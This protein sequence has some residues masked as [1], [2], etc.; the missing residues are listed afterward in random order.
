MINTTSTKKDRLTRSR[1]AGCL[2]LVLA[3]IVIFVGIQ[4]AWD[5][6]DK[7]VRIDDIA[8]VYYDSF[9]NYRYLVRQHDGSMKMESRSYMRADVRIYDDTPSED[10][11]YALEYHNATW[12]H[13]YSVDRVEIHIHKTSSLKAGEIRNSH[14][15][16]PKEIKR[17]IHEPGNNYSRTTY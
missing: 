4:S 5:T 14:S 12:L 9:D 10:K 13:T 3:L 6:P 16:K 11:M 1:Q 17:I 7:V 15:Y 2:G 8:E